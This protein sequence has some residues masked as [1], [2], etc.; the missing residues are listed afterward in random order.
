M[1]KYLGFIG[2]ILRR[3]KKGETVFYTI[4]W[5]MPGYLPEME[6]YTISADNAAL[7]DV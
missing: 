7:N 6:P 3:E 5:D 1:S 4:L 2:R